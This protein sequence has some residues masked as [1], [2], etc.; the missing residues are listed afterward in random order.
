M[1]GHLNVK[2]VITGV[3]TVVFEFQQH[4]RDFFFLL[5]KGQANKPVSPSV[6]R[7]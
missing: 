1:H 4:S 5:Y 3:G 2:F 6:Q 7:P